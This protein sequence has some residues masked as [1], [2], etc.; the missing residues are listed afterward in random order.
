MEETRRVCAYCGIPVE[1]GAIECPK[2]GGA[3]F[4]EV[5]IEETVPQTTA[6]VTEEKT[7]PAS[8]APTIV[9]VLRDVDTWKKVV[10]FIVGTLLIIVGFVMME[11]GES[12][13]Y[14]TS[15][16]GDFYT[17][18]YKGIVEISQQ[19]EVLQTTLSWLL[20]AIGA[21]IDVKMLHD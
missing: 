21:A 6:A 17:Y 15:F 16:G 12:G 4:D 20:V 13:I 2:C 8:V 5:T 18:A 10:G 1:E 11:K 7:A 9:P 14:R 19:L 3:K